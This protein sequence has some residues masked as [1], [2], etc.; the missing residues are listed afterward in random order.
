MVT[1]FALEILVSRL[2]MKTYRGENWTVGCGRGQLQLFEWSCSREFE[3]HCSLISTDKPGE[4][5]AEGLSMHL[6]SIRLQ[7]TW[8]LEYNKNLKMQTMK[9]WN[10]VF[11]LNCSLCFLLHRCSN[12]QSNSNISYFCLW[13]IISIREV[14]LRCGI[15]EDFLGVVSSESLRYSGNVSLRL[16]HLR[17][18][19]CAWPWGK[20]TDMLMW[21]V[22]RSA[23]PNFF[24]DIISPMDLL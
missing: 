11:S 9:I 5:I 20:K 17:A 24:F 2:V 1:W 4:S 3:S 15:S 13:I 8:A 18:I 12:L 23:Q 16:Q 6:C 21:K 19:F 10:K 14:W 22:H 7:N